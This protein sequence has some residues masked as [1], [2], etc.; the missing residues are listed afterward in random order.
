MSGRRVGERAEMGRGEHTTDVRAGVSRAGEVVSI[1]LEQDAGM[2]GQRAR[3]REQDVPRKQYE[4]GRGDTAAVT[5]TIINGARGYMGRMT[6]LGG[7]GQGLS[8]VATR[9]RIRIVE[10]RER[11]NG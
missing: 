6:E 5:S 11:K 1:L 8:L 9:S 10:N 2:G 7:R 3:N 4:H